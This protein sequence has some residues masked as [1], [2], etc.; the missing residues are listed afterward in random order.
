MYDILRIDAVYLRWGTSLPP[1]QLC[2]KTYWQ[3]E[4]ATLCHSP[5]QRRLYPPLGCSSNKRHFTL[6]TARQSSHI[7]QIKYVC[8]ST[9]L[10]Y[11]K[12]STQAR[13]T[14][15]LLD[16]YCRR[17]HM[18]PQLISA[19]C[20]Y[21]NKTIPIDKI[22]ATLH[23]F[24]FIRCRISFRASSLLF[25]IPSKKKHFFQRIF[26]SFAKFLQWFF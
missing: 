1:K 25:S 21:L 13:C 9:V 8:G 16:L 23:Q 26:K 22:A 10:A 3:M 5:E 24:F 12:K 6:W 2:R 19:R 11:G 14:Y 7:W 17:A 20:H 4:P 15:H 18:E